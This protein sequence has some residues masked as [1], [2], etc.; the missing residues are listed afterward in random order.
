MEPVLMLTAFYEAI[1]QDARISPAHISLYMALFQ[2]LGMKHFQ[3]PVSFSSHEI[4]PMA[5]IDSRATYHRCLKDLVES[6]YIRYIPSCNPF[7]KSLA[8]LELSI[9]N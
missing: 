6:G 7:L 9:R 2:K 5:K 8:F 1:S 3:N 4:M